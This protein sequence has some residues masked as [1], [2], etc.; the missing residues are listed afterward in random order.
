MKGRI[1]EDLPYMHGELMQGHPNKILRQDNAKENVAAIKMAQEKHWKIVF[2]AEFTARKT[3]QQNLIAE[4]VFTVIAAHA[5]SM[6]NTV[7]LPD[8]LRFKLWAET[9]MTATYLNNLVIVTL[10]RE[11]KTQWEHARFKLPLWIKNLCTCEE[12]GTVKEGKRRKVL[13]WGVTMMFI[14]YN[15]ENP[16]NCFRMYNPESSKVTLTRDIIWLGWMYYPRR[17]AKVT[18]LLP[19]VA[20]PISQY[21]TDVEEENA[22]G[23]K[24]IIE[25]P[26]IS[27]EREGTISDKSSSEKGE[28]SGWIVHRTCYTRLTG[29]KSGMYNPSTGK[30]VQ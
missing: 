20:V 10:N 19:I 26:L 12:A 14:G 29:L 18:Q 6:M 27:K 4:M 24:I 16:E 13:D 25:G 2:K 9:V 11:K 1:I 30:A 15:Q 8:K 3:P 17:N 28:D 7:Q 5:R 22:A 23:I 21:L